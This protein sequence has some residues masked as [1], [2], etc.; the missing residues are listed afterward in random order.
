ME[1]PLETPDNK[2]FLRR[3]RDDAADYETIGRWLSDAQ[4]LAF[5]GGE[6]ERRDAAGA[7]TTYRPQILGE[8]PVNPCF[9][10]LRGRPIGYLQ[11]YPVLDASDY[12]LADA[13]GTWGVDMFIGEPEL[14]GQGL[15]RRA[16][17]LIASALLESGALRVVIDPALSNARAIRAYEAAGFRRVTVLGA[18]EEHDGEPVDCWL[19]ER[20]PSSG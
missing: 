10:E 5:Y 17:D 20:S 6:A 15:G 7:R 4:V 8:T 14:W 9:I 18:H 19:M 16:L 2:L 1:L 11:F 13:T 12:Q 3:M